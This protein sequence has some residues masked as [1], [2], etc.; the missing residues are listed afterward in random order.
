V[1]TLIYLV[2][3]QAS[4]PTKNQRLKESL[5]MIIQRMQAAYGGALAEAV[6]ATMLC[7]VLAVAL[8]DPQ[9]STRQAAVITLA[10]SYAIYGDELVVRIR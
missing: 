6:S 9:S 10:D 5:L 2:L 7:S 3:Y 1:V 8:N 4:I